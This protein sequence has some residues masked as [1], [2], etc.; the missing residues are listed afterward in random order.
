MYY[1]LYSALIQSLYGTLC[2]LLAAVLEHAQSPGICDEDRGA[3][4]AVHGIRKYSFVCPSVGA[5]NRHLLC[6]IGMPRS[7]LHTDKVLASMSPN[8]DAE[9]QTGGHLPWLQLLSAES[10]F[11]HVLRF[12]CEVALPKVR[13]GL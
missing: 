12:R 7:P 1:A 10:C 11:W 6:I 4:V 13:R 5:L 8:E 9:R 3:G 2:G